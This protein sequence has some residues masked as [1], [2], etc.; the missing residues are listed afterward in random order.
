MARAAVVHQQRTKVRYGQRAPIAAP[1][2]SDSSLLK[3][4]RS[5]GPRSY[6]RRLPA[7]SRTLGTLISALFPLASKSFF[8]Q[9]AD[10]GVVCSEVGSCLFSAQ[11]DECLLSAT[12]RLT[13]CTFL[14][15]VCEPT[16]GARGILKRDIRAYAEFGNFPEGPD[17]IDC[18]P[19]KVDVRVGPVRKAD[20]I[21]FKGH[22]L[23][24][25]EYGHRQVITAQPSVKGNSQNMTSAH[26]KDA[27]S[28]LSKKRLKSCGTVFLVTKVFEALAACSCYQFRLCPVHGAELD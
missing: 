4:M 12:Y 1:T 15:A 20:D 3:V 18:L 14:G 25:P 9:A 17:L 19:F 8:N 11:I 27:L 23:E 22:V 5:G 6:P 7:S 16:L 26:G 13:G 10:S 28:A 24:D 2:R 21:M